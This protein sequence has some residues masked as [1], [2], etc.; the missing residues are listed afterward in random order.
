MKYDGFIASD[1]GAISQAYRGHQYTECIEDAVL[2][3]VEATCDVNSGHGK[4]YRTGPGYGTSSP[5]TDYIPSLVESGVLSEELVDN[6][7][8][9][10]L[11]VRF[12]LGLFDQPVTKQ[13]YF[14]IPP[15]VVDSDE[16]KKLNLEAAHQAMT[17]LKNDGVLPFSKD[18][19]DSNNSES[20]LVYAVIGPHFNATT[21]LLIVGGY[22]G[23]TCREFGSTD[24]VPSFLK[25]GME[26]YVDSKY[27]MYAE[28]CDGVCHVCS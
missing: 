5:F 1:S 20:K 13:I 12:E 6:A 2:K 25:N 7:L 19:V 4:H 18:S 15:N 3:A 9:R 14:N 22:T 8:Y 16:H 24:C 27:L 11:K 21:D 17:L 28:G 23:Q 26:K 10:S